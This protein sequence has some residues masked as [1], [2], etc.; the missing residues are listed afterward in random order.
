MDE[1]IGFG[2]PTDFSY[3]V[4]R[5][6]LSKKYGLFGRVPIYGGMKL[7]EYYPPLSTV[8]FR[9]LTSLGSLIFYF[10]LTFIVW[11]FFRGPITAIMFLASYFIITPL[12]YLG[13]FP[14][15]FGHTLAV[16]AYFVYDGLILNSVVSGIL[17]GVGGL[18]HPLPMAFGSFILLI[19]MIMKLEFNVIPYLITLG[20]C[21]WWYIPF[22]LRCRRFP[23]LKE[24]RKDKFLGIY[25][26]SWLPMGT[27]IFFLFF[28]LLIAMIT[29][30]P[31]IIPVCVA[32]TREKIEVKKG[33]AA[34]RFTWGLLRSKPLFL[35]KFSEKFPQLDSI[36]DSI[37]AIKQKGT[38]VSR[39]VWIWAIACYLYVKK[40]IIVYNGLPGTEV[41]VDKLKI[42]ENIPIIEISED[43]G[44]G[45]KALRG[46]PKITKI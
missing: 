6:N 4:L 14:E 22:I 45:D 21:G 35:S 42:P 37:V 20:V 19:K 2:R 39:S 36:R 24:K 28:P 1:I 11:S 23:Y 13:R 29:L 17:L 8:L 10:I 43:V 25:G 40:G 3:L 27:I 15:I 34:W 12:I 41:S 46:S 30:L 32:E 7:H 44:Y 38:T 33:L 31:W 9:Y 18:F 5:A 26:F 16:A